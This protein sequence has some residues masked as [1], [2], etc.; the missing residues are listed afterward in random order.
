[1]TDSSQSPFASL[2]Q[3]IRLLD[4][5]TRTHILFLT[6][7]ITIAGLLEGLG[8]GLIAPLL[9]MASNPESSTEIGF[10]QPIISTF[11]LNPGK[12]LILT[13]S[14]FLLGFIVLKNVMLVGIYYMQNRIVFGTDWLMAIR[15]FRHY[16]Y[17][18]YLQTAARNSADLIRNISNSIDICFKGVLLGF[19][20]IFTEL[21]TVAAIG[22]VLV[23]VAPEA[24]LATFAILGVSITLYQLLI[25]GRFTRWG[26]RE[27]DALRMLYQ[28]LQQGL[29][30]LKTTKAHGREQVLVDQFATAKRITYLTGTKTNTVNQT[31][32]LW[33]E[34]MIV[35]A[36]V[37]VI[38]ILLQIKGDAQS[39]IPILGLFAAAAFRLMPSINRSL[40]ALNRIRQGTA[41]MEAVIGDLRDSTHTLKNDAT[42]IPGRPLDFEE[43]SF[44]NVSMAYPNAL[45]PAVRDLNF[46]IEKGQSIGIVGVSGAGKTTLVDLMLGLLTPINGEIRVNG[47]LLSVQLP[48]W[49]RTI[50]YVPQSVYV[51][52]DTVR[53]NIAFGYKDE[54]IDDD[55]IWKAIDTAQLRSF[56]EELPHGL[57]TSMG[58]HGFRMSGGQ[59][60]RLS[61]TRALYHDPAVIILDEA[62]SALDYTTERDVWE[63]I[64]RLRHEKT[65]IVIAHRIN[66]VRS[67]NRIIYI[68]AGRIAAVG[69]YEQLLA[70]NTNFKQLVD[71]GAS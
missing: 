63:S 43:L 30:S 61:L 15:L 10:I 20:E 16:L 14:F 9:K 3:L 26:R 32:R 64:D 52:D 71:S 49:Q 40:M 22:S 5:R 34:T 35:L 1:M 38:A 44:E 21:C 68:D 39:I 17:S 31:P 8:V 29:H 12:E 65:I 60:Q 51:F 70:N 11:G 2:I 4:R 67:C 62:T 42:S 59:Q 18:P 50:G 48:N 69:S 36:M 13:Y 37:V 54:D 7:L 33:V 23:V 27:H 45:L 53:R 55:R 56:V 66:T 24:A 19:I 6:L 58:E 47:Q 25:R 57:D 28:S 46:T 41:A